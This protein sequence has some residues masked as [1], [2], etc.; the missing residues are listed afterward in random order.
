[1]LSLDEDEGKLSLTLRPSDLKLLDTSCEDVPQRLLSHFR[2]YVS[3]RSAI[4]G[5]LKARSG[6]T[7]GKGG[8]SVAQLARAFAPGGRV[9]G[10]VTTLTDESVV[11]ELEVG[12]RGRIDRASIH[13]LQQ[14]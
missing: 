11:V 7:T 13:G 10:H 3:E 12:V 2:D 1:M 6:E 5:E 9:S 4:L 8:S 14:N